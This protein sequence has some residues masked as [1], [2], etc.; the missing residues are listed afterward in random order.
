[1]DGMKELQM[2]DNDEILLEVLDKFTKRKHIIDQWSGYAVCSYCFYHQSHK[3][4]CIIPKAEK[5]QE[6]LLVR[7]ERHQKLLY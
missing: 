5:L 6:E 7:V 3:D 4:D 1:M 2:T